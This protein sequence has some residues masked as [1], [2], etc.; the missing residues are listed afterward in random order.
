MNNDRR[1][2]IET[3]LT[4]LDAMD[5]ES[6]SG[7]LGDVKDEEQ[8]AFDNMPEGVKNT[9]KGEKS[10]EAISALESIIYWLDNASEHIEILRSAIE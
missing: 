9:E 1:K 4:L 8:I 6:M 3:V 5:W 10:Q 7:I 2:S